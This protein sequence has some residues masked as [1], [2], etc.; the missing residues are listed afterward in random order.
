MQI[1]R[2]KRDALFSELVRERANWTCEGCGK[3]SERRFLQCAHIFGRRHRTTRFS[4][5]NALCLCFGCHRHF[6]ENPVEFANWCAEK[7]GKKEMERLG[8]LS[9][10]VAAFKKHTL[11]EIQVDLKVELDFM[12]KARSDGVT[13]R[14]E[15]EAPRAVAALEA[16]LK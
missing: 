7:F 4:P 10:V 6:T 12:K 9:K 15:F 13:G 3:A 8:R 2:D 5:Q 14:L 11:A 16:S 1:R